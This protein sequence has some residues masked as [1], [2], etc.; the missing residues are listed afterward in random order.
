[1]ISKK[2]NGLELGNDHLNRT[3]CVDFVSSIASSIQDTLREKLSRTRFY[4][5]LSDSSTD[6]SVIDQE[7]IMVRFLDPDSKS[8]IT[9]VASIE[10]LE[11]PDANG[12]FETISRGLKTIDIELSCEETVPA[13]VCVSMDGASV[14]MGAKNGVA[15]KLSDTVT[16][17]VIV[18]HCVAHRL[19]LG[20]LDAAKKASYIQDFEGVI[21][22]IYKF[23]SRSPKRRAHLATLSEILDNDLVM[24]T[25]IKSIRWVCN[26][27]ILIVNDLHLPV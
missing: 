1:M 11:T 2:K 22:R 24:Y 3:A 13:L 23:Y 19:E 16:H 6:K 9:T 20:I 17:P 26:T 21:K 10:P 7:C 27:H 14:N 8:P 12:V 25:N 15:K 18:T 4:S 5:V